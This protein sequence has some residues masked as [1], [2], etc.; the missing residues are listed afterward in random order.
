LQFVVRVLKRAD[1]ASG[2]GAHEWGYRKYLPQAPR[3]ARRSLGK[4]IEADH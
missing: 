2:S 1:G 4:L 3:V